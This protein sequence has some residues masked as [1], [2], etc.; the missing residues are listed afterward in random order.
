M[1]RRSL[2][3]VQKARDEQLF[4]ECP[5]VDAEKSRCCL[6]D[7]NVLLSKSGDRPAL[8]RFLRAQKKAGG[9]FWITETVDGELRTPQHLKPLSC[10][11]NQKEMSRPRGRMRRGVFRNLEPLTFKNDDYS[12]DKSL[13]T[14]LRIIYDTAHYAQQL[15]NTGLNGGVECVY[16]TCNM[17]QLRVA[18]KARNRLL[19]EN[20]LFTR[21]FSLP[22][23]FAFVNAHLDREADEDDQQFNIRCSR[24]GTLHDVSNLILP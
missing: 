15:E 21:K 10:A 17:N 12:R 23:I 4:R 8:D 14:A 6:F 9:I 16:V 11:H 19:I 22:R 7:T 5:L 13:E 3:A 18:L 24:A 20:N 1:S 2:R